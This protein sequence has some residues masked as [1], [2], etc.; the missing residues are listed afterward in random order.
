VVDQKASIGIG[1]MIVFIALILV[2]AVA[3]TIIISSVE[4]LSQTMEDTTSVRDYSK[5]KVDSVYTFLYEPCWQKDF[6]ELSQ[7]TLMAP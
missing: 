5:I 2:A 1:A 3:S 6:T 4:D 7:C